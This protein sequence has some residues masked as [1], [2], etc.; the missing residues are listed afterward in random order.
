VRRVS[1]SSDPGAPGGEPGC[2]LGILVSGRGSN[3][4]AILG[5]VA[6]RRLAGV[7]PVLVVSNR[8]SVPALAVA[9]DHGVPVSVLE[10]AAFPS[11]AARDAAIGAALAERG[12]DLV[13]LAGYDQL[14][15]GP[16]FARY[17]GRTI[18]IHPSLL[19]RHGGKGMMGMAVH[20]AVLAAGDPETGVTIHEVTPELDAGPILARE[21]VAVRRGESAEELA[22]RVLPVEHRL[23][24]ATIAALARDGFP[25]GASATMAAAPGA[26]NVPP[27]A[28]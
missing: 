9:A 6:D 21:R 10:R 25:A 11:A 26:T 23:L 28:P 5:A 8:R 14:L 3:L 24:V 18:N 19:P 15:R 16:Y 12:V 2:R 7:E 22:A 20:R 1:P 27:R 17:R 4:G 13:V